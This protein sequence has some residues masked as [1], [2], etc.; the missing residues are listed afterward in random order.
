VCS[1]DLEVLLDG[2][3]SIYGSDAIGGTLNFITRSRFEGVEAT[4]TNGFDGDHYRNHSLSI[5]GGTDWGSG[6]G[7][8]SLYAH[9]NSALPAGDRNTPAQD[10]TPYGYSDFRVRTCA[11]G[12]IVAGGV[13]YALP[14]RQPGTVNLCDTAQD[15][16]VA[17]RE[18][19][20]GGYLS[21]TQTL[22]DDLEIEVKAYG[23]RRATSTR[24]TQLGNAS[25]LVNATN[26]F[27]D[28]V[29][30]ETQHSV[31]FS[32]AS[33]LGPYFHSR[34]ELTQ[35]DI[36]PVLTWQP[37]GN[38][39]V[40]LLGDYGW[41]KTV[42]DIPGLN[43]VAEAAALRGAGLTTDTAL[44]PYDL[45]LTNP[46]VIEKIGDWGSHAYNKQTL[47]QARLTA[48]GTAFSL[49]G[50]DAR[51]A[52]GVQIT[53]LTAHGYSLTGASGTT[54]GAITAGK[55]RTVTSVF[56]QFVVPIFGEGNALP[57][58]RSLDIDLSAR[59]DH[60][61][62]IGSTTNP[63]I[64]LSWEPVS[65]LKFRGNWGKAFTAPSI[66][67]T[68][69]G[70][71]DAQV[72][73]QNVQGLRPGDPASDRNRA[74]IVLTGGTQG[75]K[76]QRATTWSA[77]F[78]F[79]PKVVPGFEFNATYWK[80]DIKDVISS[81]V[82]GGTLQSNLAIPELYGTYFIYRPTLAQALE[83]AK[84]IQ[85]ISGNASSI[86][87]LYGSGNDPYLIWDRRRRNTGGFKTSGIELRTAYRLQTDWGAIRAS[88]SGSRVLTRKQQ[89]YATGPYTDQL[90]ANFSKFYA[91]GIVGVDIGRLTASA[92]VNYTQGF[93]ITGVTGQ[94]HLGAFA[95]VNLFFSYTVGDDFTISANID[96]VG[97]DM[98]DIVN[99]S[100]G[101]FSGASLQQTLGRIYS[102]SVRKAF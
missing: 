75:V 17:P 91:Q 24:T 44:N 27:F 100:G 102:I 29:R 11:P 86:E 93:D 37:G 53:R 52:A 80:V 25:A 49:P 76:P 78:D 73:I 98:P 23:S 32:Y 50:G 34:V 95:P 81:G 61:Q 21:L 66:S 85:I 60:Y 84:G 68:M 4:A 55:G 65:G 30:N 63:K 79:T 33:V 10:L 97:N 35:Y 69:I 26:P 99:V 45:T 9:R 31:A 67:D 48:D 1:S 94:T 7:V 74:Q 18:W 87:S 70:G 58:L 90:G 19:Q 13:T 71:I 8:I 36:S 89:Q 28:P 14:D 57:G 72:M 51:V 39:R 41:S 43:T 88:F 56:G 3:S 54:T 12:T 62:E 15:G 46:A 22:G 40:R 59:Y 6:H 64:G 96:N 82:P 101:Q 83:A 2:G 5:T 47:A 38:W 16:V 20:L 92:T 42:Q 77:G